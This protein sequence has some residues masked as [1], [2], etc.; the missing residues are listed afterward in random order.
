MLDTERAVRSLLSEVAPWAS[1]DCEVR[2]CNV[3]QV[4]KHLGKRMAFVGLEYTD[5][6]GRERRGRVVLKRDGRRRAEAV[7]HIL[8]QLRD[9]GLRPPAQVRVPEPL[10]TSR[11][12][13]VLVQEWVAGDPWADTLGTPDARLASARAAGWL[14]TL[15]AL[16]VPATVS[17][18]HLPSVRRYARELVDA[19]PS[20]AAGIRQLSLRLLEGLGSVPQP[21]VPSH[22]DLHPKNVLI[23]GEVVTVVDLD[24]FAAREPAFDV[25]YAVGELIIMATFRLGEPEA[26]L[27]AAAAFWSGYLQSGG[28]AAPERVALHAARTF[29][30]NLHYEL[31]VLRNSKNELLHRWPELAWEWMDSDGLAPLEGALRNR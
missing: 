2:E 1:M 12:G 23:D 26:G 20:E 8:R 24:T 25:G 11:D 15:Q 3:V 17:E 10:G 14:A 5:D 13:Q 27:E 28:T 30:Q 22:G 7:H 18:A 29:F 4:R 9:S 31:C 21:S 6:G 19:Y 16:P